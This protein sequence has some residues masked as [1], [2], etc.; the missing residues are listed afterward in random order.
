MMSNEKTS[1]NNVNA[2]P[3]IKKLWEDNMYP[4]ISNEEL[5]EDMIDSMALES[6]GIDKK[7]IRRYCDSNNVE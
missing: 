4:M 5:S 2:M 6:N 7:A 3:F 1:E